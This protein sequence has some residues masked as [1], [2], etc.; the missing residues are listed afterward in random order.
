MVVL[1]ICRTSVENL[2]VDAEFSYF[3]G[4]ESFSLFRDVNLGEGI[5]WRTQVLNGGRN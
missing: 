1:A 4:F 3:S 2:E 5:N